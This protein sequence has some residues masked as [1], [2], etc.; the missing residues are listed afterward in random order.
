MHLLDNKV[1]STTIYKFD[2]LIEEKEA[3]AIED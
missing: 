1:F 2:L 3:L